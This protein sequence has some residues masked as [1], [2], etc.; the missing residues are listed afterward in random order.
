MFILH[1]Q[2]QQDCIELGRF[3]LC[4]LLL[5]N[6]SRY[7]WCVLVPQREGI[8]EIHELETDDQRRL[9]EESVRLGRFLEQE[10]R[11]HKLNVAALGNMVPQLHVHHIVR[12]SHDQAWPR[13]VWG[14]GDA[15][16][17]S[18]EGLEEMRARFRPLIADS[19]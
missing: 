10:F 17:Y 3:A 7:P 19:E 4:R 9:L 11:A 18:S 5:L 1:P 2:L 8:R 6:D 12:Y 15:V 16:P 13:P 14:L